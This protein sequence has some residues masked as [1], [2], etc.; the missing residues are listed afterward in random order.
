MIEGLA[1]RLGG[2][3][4]IFAQKGRQFELPQMMCEQHLGRFRTG[5]RRRRGNVALPETRAI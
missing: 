2:D 1:R 5:G 3:F 4:V